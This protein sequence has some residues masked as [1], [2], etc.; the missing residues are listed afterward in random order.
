MNDSITAQNQKTIHV[1]TVGMDRR[2]QAMFR[3]AFEMHTLHRYQLLEN[4]AHAAPALAIVDFD[5][6]DAP[7]LWDDFRGQHPELPALIVTTTPP[8]S[9]P[10]PV[11]LKPIRLETLFPRLRQLLAG[12]VITTDIEAPRSV[13]AASASPAPH[14]EVPAAPAPLAASDIQAAS[15]AAPEPPFDQNNGISLEAAAPIRVPVSQWPKRVER[16]DPRVGLLGALLKLKRTQA[17]GVI[18]IAGMQ[19]IIVI[20]N[21][22]RA[23]LSQPESALREACASPTTLIASR[24]LTQDD[25]LDAKSVSLTGLLWQVA[26]WTSRG[27]LLAGFPEQGSVHLRY[28]PNLTRL[29]PFPNGLRIAAFWVRSPTTLPLTLRMLHI[30]PEEML[31]FLAAAYSIGILEIPKAESRPTA[32]ILAEAQAAVSQRPEPIAHHAA[33]A[34]SMQD[35]PKPRGGLLSRLLRKVAG[36]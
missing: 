13:V 35:I 20:P 1:L 22:D 26:S 16:F 2:K 12:E 18:S 21:Q 6:P 32:K 9:A 4:I 19:A 14:T 29:A 30:P 36:L 25:Q 3:M 33:E 27:R 7:A 34:A 10:A 11:L 15:D 23:L 5:T 8:R 31:D 24:P 28:W 17:A